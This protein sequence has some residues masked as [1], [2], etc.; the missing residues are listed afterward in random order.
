MGIGI[1][2]VAASSGC[3]VFLY[4]AN[5]AQTEK[6]LEGLQKIL[7]RLVEKNKIDFD[8]SE[9]IYNKIQLRFVIEFRI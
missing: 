5:S 3:D 8:E 7:A 9:N 4:D 6:S 1:A 2:Q